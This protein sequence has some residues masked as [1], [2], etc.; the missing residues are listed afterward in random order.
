MT[1]RH[2]ITG[3]AQVGEVFVRLFEPYT[4]PHPDANMLPWAVGAM[5]RIKFT[6]GELTTTKRMSQKYTWRTPGGWAREAPPTKAEIRDA[7][8]VV[9]DN[10]REQITRHGFD[11]GPLK[12]NRWPEWPHYLGDTQP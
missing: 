6:I 2:P 5:C 3:T 11:P 4:D 8:Y 9:L 12:P 1:R 7:T 10:L